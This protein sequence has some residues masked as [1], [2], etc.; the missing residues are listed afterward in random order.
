MTAMVPFHR[1]QEENACE[2][3]RELAKNY[4]RDWTAM[5]GTD[6]TIAARD[7]GPEVQDYIGRKWATYIRKNIR[8]R[9]RLATTGNAGRAPRSQRKGMK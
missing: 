5:Q 4:K 6:W 1:S 8:H 3:M 9:E 2:D 7:G